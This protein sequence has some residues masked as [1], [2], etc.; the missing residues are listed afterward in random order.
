MNVERNHHQDLRQAVDVRRA[1]AQC[2]APGMFAVSLFFLICQAV[3][4][5][6]LVDMPNFSEHVGTAIDPGSP[7]H[8]WLREIASANGLELAFYDVTVRL[9]WVLWPIVIAES[10]FHWLTRPWNSRTWR[11]H[12]LGLMYCICPSFRMCA[13]SHEMRNRIWLPGLGWRQ[14]NRRLRNRLERRF[15]LP[16]IAIAFLILP[17][18]VIEFFLHQ[19]VENSMVLW[20]LLH[21]GTGVIWLAFAFEFILMVSVA[22]KKLAY[23]KEHWLDL[24]IILLPLISF[25]RSV[26]FVRATHALK[27]EQITKV[28]RV[29]RMRGT[30]LKALRGL[31]V[32]EL[33]S[34]FFRPDADQ[35]IEGLK[36]ELRAA[37]DRVREIRR[38]I[39]KVDRERLENRET[40][41]EPAL[42]CDERPRQAQVASQPDRE[43][44]AVG[45][46]QT[47]AGATPA[48]ALPGAESRPLTQAI[49]D[50]AGSGDGRLASRKT[51]HMRSKTVFV[52]RPK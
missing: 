37:E 25:L 26:Q 49:K 5:V 33:F 36:G 22:E 6:I 39:A 29:Y 18:L 20:W 35:V 1:V 24:A 27:L 7:T 10:I 16:M 28:L 9:L 13:R 51:R 46:N 50:G 43:N 11:L 42:D 4:V 34:R 52:P 44:T 14:P 8:G 32:L 31:I 15:S 17:V 19:Q 21:V 23:C 38:K 47:A 45:A 41:S 40:P 30:A 2:M 3:L 48:G 12:L